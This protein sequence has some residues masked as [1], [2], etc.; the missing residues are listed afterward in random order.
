MARAAAEGRAPEPPGAAVGRH[1][2][3]V[4]VLGAVE[5][6][7]VHGRGVLLVPEL[8]LGE[9]GEVGPLGVVPQRGEAHVALVRGE[10]EPLRDLGLRVRVRV[11]VRG[12]E[13]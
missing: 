4:L 11:R 12:V 3:R 13:G 2:Q 10:Q 5:L 6:H 8:L 7:E 9:V 1:E